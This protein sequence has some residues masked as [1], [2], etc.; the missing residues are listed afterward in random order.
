LREACKLTHR[1]ELRCKTGLNSEAGI[2]AGGLILVLREGAPPRSV[3]DAVPLPADVKLVAVVAGVLKTPEILRDL[4]RLR[5]VE[6]KGD[7]Y[8]ELIL[9][10]PTLENFLERSREFAYEAGFVTYEVEEIFE[11]MERLPLIG[12]AQNML[13]KAGHGLV[14]ESRLREVERDLRDYFPD[15]EVIV[16]DIGYGVRASIS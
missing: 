2:L 16:S 8:M 14:L 5:E 3:I 11:V 10:K 1:V 13:G 4:E 7:K 6:E 12:Y 15:R 9:R